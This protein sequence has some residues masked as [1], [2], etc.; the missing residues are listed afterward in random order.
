MLINSHRLSE[1]RRNKELLL[2]GSE[3]PSRRRRCSRMAPQ[4]GTAGCAETTRGTG[5]KGNK[6]SRI[7]VSKV[8]YYRVF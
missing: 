7:G 5:V 1:G 2:R 3:S 6:R 4:T 8:Y